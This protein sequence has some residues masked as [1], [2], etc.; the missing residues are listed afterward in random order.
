MKLTSTFK[1]VLALAVIGLIGLAAA[2]WTVSQ[3]A[4]IDAI[5]HQI[6]ER[7]GL[8]LARHGRSVFA[9]LP[10]PHIRIYEPQFRDADGDLSVTASSLRVDLGF[11]G[12]LTGR[13][14]LAR[15]ML[16]DAVF[17]LDPSHLPAAVMASTVR[18]AN[19]LGDLEIVHGQLYLRRAGGAPQELAA[20]DI[21]ARVEWSRVGAPL[22]LSGH[23]RVTAIGEDRQPARFALWAAQPGRLLGAGTS[24]VTLRFEDE[25]LQIVLDGALALG[26]RTHF[27]GQ[28]AAS[29]AS[30]RAAAG[31]FGVAMPLPGPYRDA[32]VKADA[33]LDAGQLGL[34][35][36]TMTVDGNTLDG[37]ASIRF[38]GQRPSAAATLASASVNF[39]PM[40][41]DYPSAAVGGQ[42]SR[43]PFPPA[44]LGAADLDLRLSAKRA[45]IGDIQL[46]DAALSIIQKSGRLDV[47][48]AQAQAYSG[49]ARARAVVTESG[50]GL[51]IRG[52]LSAEKLDVAPLLW[53]VGKRQ[54][55]TGTGAMSASFETSGDS[56]AELASH[57]DAR[58]DFSVEAGEIYGIDLDLAFRRMESRP[59]SVASDLHSGRTA[60]DLLSAK[61]NIMQGV[62]DIE[63]GAARGGQNAM[64]F[65]GRAN[66]AERSVDLHA[67]ANRAGAGGKG[68]QFGFNISGAWDDPAV[69]P[70]AE[71]LIRRSDAA[72][73]LLPSSEPAAP[74]A[75]APTASP[76]R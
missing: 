63:E 13:L 15:A 20:D 29:A 19:G 5:E 76:P 23:A 75:A 57:L 48:L 26:P 38:D 11:G 62:A 17:T 59:L 61:F 73:P 49:F 65:S 36:L 3:S 10:R 56:F 31:L 74:A 14:D 21:G 68:L 58:G 64:F 41:E 32:R 42:W 24:P 34:A 2:P 25:S 55:V 8:T 53:D 4:Q 16:S 37:A 44:R 46:E 52:S 51:D 72:A 45:Q 18:P 47:S 40:F 67:S 28:I 33:T 30:L 69:I 43:D 22:S 66:F 9:V 1:G 7:A 70:D 60:F 71:G 35:N 27:E 6:R 54:V 39:A 12:L 50:A